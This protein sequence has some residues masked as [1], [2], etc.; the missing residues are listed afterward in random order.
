M[1]LCL[2][3]G[4]LE[5][6]D[7][8]CIMPPRTTAGA[9]KGT[10]C[11]QSILLEIISFSSQNPQNLLNLII[12]YYTSFKFI[13]LLLNSGRKILSLCS[14]FIFGF[15]FSFSLFQSNH[16]INPKLFKLYFLYLNF[17][18]VNTSSGPRTAVQQ[19]VRLLR[20]RRYVS[21]WT[22]PVRTTAD[23]TERTLRTD[24]SRTEGSWYVVKKYI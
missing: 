20:P 17:H 3:P 11:S 23:G 2:C 21:E 10:F 18:I 4:E 1:Y 16:V 22:M 8:Q 9:V 19:P 15:F 5:D 6:H 7:G 13:Y 24:G 14:A 12:E